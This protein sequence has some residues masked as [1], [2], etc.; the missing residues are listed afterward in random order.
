MLVAYARDYA[1]LT[2]TAGITIPFGM[3]LS[4]PGPTKVNH[5]RTYHHK[6][7]I[8]QY[9]TYYQN[10][11][12]MSNDVERQPGPKRRITLI[13]N[14]ILILLAIALMKMKK[15]EYM[16][17]M[18]PRKLASYNIKNEAWNVLPLKNRKNPQIETRRNY[19][20]LIMLILL[21][22]DIHPNPGP[23]EQNMCL[24]CK[25]IENNLQSVTCN[26]CNGWSH[27]NCSA[28]PG[29]QEN[30][31]LIDQSFEWLCPNPTCSPNH[32][33]GL[34]NHFQTTANRFNTLE[35]CEKARMK[36]STKSK[37]DTKSRRP[38]REQ[39]EKIFSKDNLN[40]LKLLTRISPEEYIGKERCNTCTKSLAKNSRATKCNSCER[41]THVIC[42]DLS[43][44]E[45]MKLKN[46]KKSIWSC[47]KCRTGEITTNQVFSRKECTR[48]Q[49][50]DEW[51]LI[52]SEKKKEEEIILH[53][54]ARSIIGKEDELINIANKVKPAAIFLTETWLDDSCP[55]GT[56][57][58]ANYTV[59]RHDRSTEF[60][61]KYGKTNGGGVAVLIRKGVKI[62]LESNLTDVNTEILWCSLKM[63]STKYLVGVMYRAS[64]TE[65][66][67]ANTEG[68]TKMEELLQ[69]TLHHNIMII[70]D[71]NCDTSNPESTQD[72][73][74]L[75]NLTEEYQLKQLIQKP[76]R[77]CNTTATTI[78][79]IWVRDNSFVRKAGTCE[80]LSD[81]CGIYGYIKNCKSEEV[82]Q[83][84][85]CRSFKSFDVDKY[86]E[87]IRKMVDESSFNENIAEKDVNNAFNTWINIMKEAADKH[88]PWK[89]FKRKKEQ[90]HIPWFNEEI[91]NI[92]KTKNMYLKLYQMYNR[93]EDKK[94]YKISKNKQTHLK[95]K[96]KREY[97]TNKINQYEGESSKMWNILKDVTN[98]N[99]KEDITP[100]IVNKETANRFNS[101]FANVG[102]QVQEALN[103]T[104]KPP[105][106]NKEGTFKFEAE[107]P[108]RI[109]YLI[110]RIRPNV[111]TGHD[112][113]S[114]R[115]IKAAAPVIIED[116]MKLV[117]LSYETRIF[118]DQL[119]KAT[120]KPLH[121]KGENNDPSQYRP[122]SILTIISKVF[123][124][125]AVEQIMNY[126]NRHQLL[127]TRQHAYRTFHSTTT[128]LFE[129]IETAK[130]Y[131]DGGNLVAIAA[132][133]LSKAFDSLAHNLIL[134]KLDDMGLNESAVRWIESYLK[135]RKQTV[136]L[137]G[138][139]SDQEN[140][141]SGVPQGSI[142]GPLLFITCTNDLVKELNEYDIF[143]Y[144]DDMQIL[145]K[146]KNVQELSKKLEEAIKKSKSVLQ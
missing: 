19:I 88:A 84:I 54:N 63:E 99:Y 105:E 13:Q 76:T 144:A 65:L 31:R 92:T 80:G 10:K 111:A 146:G 81:H 36:P 40:L 102:I 117:N 9:T 104:F 46:N 107:T 145:V 71:L 34:N 109:E 38:R 17:E 2:V 75:M 126:Y 108:Q 91:S 116:L 127:N 119:K 128:C 64:Y 37:A 52:I 49:L 82:P 18:K 131:I 118:P 124:R 113:L 57:V 87:D 55:K 29:D 140:V 68:N 67:T 115:L 32:H 44:K 106:L 120:V 143:T 137:G 98:H 90:A 89:Q 59:I 97:Y 43:R 8:N 95:R 12:M 83:Q 3:R 53:F 96:L 27:L 58:P 42:S 21:A 28:L 79:H 94:L 122:I 93:P 101:F 138:I 70:G 60:K 141:E 45:Y 72:T 134:K 132:L 61:Q 15:T 20:Y 11:L 35:P 14:I 139:E 121:K 22:G 133:D 74:T 77:F 6:H 100:D 30:L 25:S 136:K 112:E 78:D 16:P 123:E 41:W 47:L 135:N 50:P 5:E 129:L 130:K 26:S 62:T 48:D 110:N 1:N 51:E 103:I 125:S 66:L 73:R 7:T 4:K 69:K 23:K 56:G 142:L 24:N 39:K 33:T 114:A 85:R 86:R